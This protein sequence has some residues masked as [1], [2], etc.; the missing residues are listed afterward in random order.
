MLPCVLD[1]FF[2]WR[3]EAVIL[4][5]PASRAGRGVTNDN[6]DLGTD[7]ANGRKPDVSMLLFLPFGSG[8]LNCWKKPFSC[9]AKL[10]LK[11]VKKE[12]TGSS[13]LAQVISCH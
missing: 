10:L 9:Q 2:S 6:S 1:V 8:G 12:E 5:A 4:G 13:R 7:L 3:M 11:P